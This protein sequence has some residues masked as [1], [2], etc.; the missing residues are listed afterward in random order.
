MGYSS[1]GK[2]PLE[3]ASKASHHHLINDP[4][5]QRTIQ[6]LWIPKAESQT[7]IRDLVVPFRR[8]AENNVD[9]IVATDG[10]YSEI[11]VRREFPSASITF[12]QFGA[13]MF[14]RDDLLKVNASAFIAPEDMSKLKTIDRLKLALAT[15]GVRSTSEKSL[16]ATV[17]AT[18]YEFFKTQTLGEKQ[19]LIDTL[20]WFLFRR[21]KTPSERSDDD[22]QW[23]LATNPHSPTGAAVTLNEAE[24][25][26]AF[27]FKCPETGK[28]IY[29]TD[30]FRLHEAIDEERGAAGILG[31]LTNTVE[32][33]VIIH[34]VR[35]LLRYSPESLKRVMFI[36]DGP[37]GFFGQTAR[38]HA[39]MR[40]LVAWLH[41]RHSLLLAGLEKSG[42]FV[43]HASEIQ[44][45][46]PNG[47]ILVLTD[48]YIYKNIL[49][50]V[51]DPNRAYAATSNYGHKV[52]FK[53]AAGQMHVVSI[54]VAVLKKNPTLA[55]LPNASQLLG[56]VEE[57]H[58]DMY[59]SALI[60]IA[61]VNKLV[62][63]SAHPS[64][65]ILEKFAKESIS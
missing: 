44:P 3:F 40:D 8:P 30:A 43:E 29:L 37:T 11:P 22:K 1:K 9:T 62:S 21:Y 53:S 27:T 54:P 28:S 52:I 10:G 36:K 58:C 42:A 26:A 45:L 56:L 38:L 33:F 63:L 39:A 61:L 18:I 19:S 16:T 4:E 23:V 14:R 48:E 47:S 31:Y 2:R 6:S 59:D 12:M 60:P 41:Q 46:M 7:P 64:S 55:D 35:Q 34:V 32:H 51:P 5:V 20:A 25:D 24:M 57:L 13:L 49:P 50:G 17:L 15:K 65:R